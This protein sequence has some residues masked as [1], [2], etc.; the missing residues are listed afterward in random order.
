[1]RKLRLKEI[2]QT[3][4]GHVASKNQSGDVNSPSNSKF[5]FFQATLPLRL[6]LTTHQCLVRVNW[7]FCKVSSA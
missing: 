4:Q 6:S 3:F 1:M 2:K 5:M 7:H